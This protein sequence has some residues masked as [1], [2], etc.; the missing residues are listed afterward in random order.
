MF[1]WVVEHVDILTCSR[2]VYFTT[3]VLSEHVIVSVAVRPECMQSHTGQIVQYCD[4]HQLLY[5]QAA[6]QLGWAGVHMGCGCAWD[7][8]SGGV[9]SF[10]V[11]LLSKQVQGGL[12]VS[13]HTSVW[14]CGLTGCRVVY[15]APAAAVV[16][17]RQ[18]SL[19][20]VLVVDVSLYI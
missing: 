13:L 2:A 16:H 1:C 11:A 20:L 6:S 12:S 17:C 10:W 9:W 8:A 15:A 5:L 14:L 3:L 19:L 7:V 18:Q 4:I